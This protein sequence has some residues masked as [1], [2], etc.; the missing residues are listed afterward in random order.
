MFKKVFA[1]LLLVCALSFPEV[2]LAEGDM[3]S[4][5]I[6][7]VSIGQGEGRTAEDYVEIHNPGLAPFNLRGH[8]LVKRTATASTDTL[9]KSWIEDTFIPAGGYYLWSNSAYTAVKSDVSTTGTLSENNGVAMR[10]GASDTGVVISGL[11]W[12]GANN[13]LSQS[14][15]PNPSAGEPLVWNGANYVSQNYT[16]HNS[17]YVPP[18]VNT[19]P[20]I[21]DDSKPMET[22]P[23]TVE[24]V[25]PAEESTTNVHPTETDI[26]SA[27]IKVEEPSPITPATN[28]SPPKIVITELLPNPVGADTGSEWVELRNDGDGE[29]DLKGW[30]LDDIA[31]LPLS[32][33]KLTLGDLI[34][35]PGE[36]RKISLPQGKF[37]LNNT[38]GDD[39]GLF[40]PEFQLIDQIS[41]RENAREG[42]SWSMVDGI[43]GWGVPTPGAV[44]LLKQEDQTVEEIAQFDHLDISFSEILPYPE[45]EDEFVELYN[46]GP[47]GS[48]DGYYLRVG[49]KKKLL[50]GLKVRRNGFVLIGSD[51]L[52]SALSNQGKTLQLINPDGDVIDELSYPIAERGSSYALV[53]DVWVWT[54]TTT[55]GKT[56]IYTPKEV[57]I[58]KVD[59]PKKAKKASPHKSTKPKPTKIIKTQP[60]DIIEQNNSPIKTA[61]AADT[62]TPPVAKGSNLNWVFLALVSVG[63][64]MLVLFKY[65]SAKSFG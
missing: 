19:P 43:W 8:R 26:V 20:V 23:A 21:A 41:F 61:L 52:P 10:R 34:I 50:K 15:V 36:Y 30:L 48:L 12:G 27:D 4:I 51:F 1:S 56:N 33:N 6:S 64:G 60:T 16:P 45:S 22:I 31:E 54:S 11:M 42:E 39:L 53:D 38:G 3:A 57:P 14:V 47:G 24:E 65:K 5:Y 62:S 7:A 63:G 25:V 17:S 28:N 18:V 13:S 58:K 32:D 59:S 37:S 9:I 2:T 55:P 49:A 44:N 46:L 29:I 35:K 40:N